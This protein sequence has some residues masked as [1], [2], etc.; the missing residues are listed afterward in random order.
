MTIRYKCEECNAALDIND[1]LAGTEGSCPRCHVVFTVP[2]PGAATAEPKPKSKKPAAT[3]KLTTE[4]EIGDFLS[5]EAPSPAPVARRTLQ[6]DSDDEI[7]TGDAAGVA[8]GGSNDDDDDDPLA[9][10]PPLSR[11][12]SRPKHDNEESDSDLETRPQAKPTRAKNTGK[13]AKKKDS[14]SSSSIAKSLMGKGEAAVEEETEHDKKK[15]RRLFGDPNARSGGEIN[16][17]GELI[18]VTLKT[19]WP[20]LIGIAAVLYGAYWM[21]G[22][23]EKKLEVPPLALVT[24]RL[25]ID[26]KPAAPGTRV[27]FIPV[28]SG[29]NLKLGTSEGLTDTNGRYAVQYTAEHPGAVIG[30]NYV[31]ITPSD[32]SQGIPPRYMMAGELQVDVVQGAKPFDFELRSDPQ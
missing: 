22:R 27:V 23:M 12:P 21:Y 5:A 13:P 30:K 10:D 26:G 6:V 19:G 18:L 17:I 2:S 3:G 16:S 25:T 11:K 14:P 15:K 28:E 1:D 7:P 20:V 32:P 31:V 9:D 4:D 8:G 24:G 29:K